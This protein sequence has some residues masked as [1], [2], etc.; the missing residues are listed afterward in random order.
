MR[1]GIHEFKLTRADKALDFGLESVRLLPP[2]AL[3]EGLLNASNA[4]SIWKYSRRRKAVE[5]L[6]K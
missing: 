5:C 6:R 1:E 3:E 2:P 4:L